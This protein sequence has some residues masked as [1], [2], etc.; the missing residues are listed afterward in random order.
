M[1]EPFFIMRNNHVDSCGIPPTITNDTTSKYYGY[2]EN[3]HGEQW[4]F[5]YDRETKKAV[6]FGGDVDWG[7]VFPVKNG[8]VE[9]LILGQAELKWLSSC[10]EAATTFDG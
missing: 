7:N 6:L 1:K 2:F 5:V 8:R 4:L 9:G 3:E 10:W